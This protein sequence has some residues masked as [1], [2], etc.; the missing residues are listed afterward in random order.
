VAGEVR[1]LR[2][3]IEEAWA[4]KSRGALVP[5]LD[6]ARQVASSSATVDYLPLHAASLYLVGNL[7]HRIGDAAAAHATLLAAARAAAMAGDDW[8]VANTWVFLVLVLGVGLGRAAEAET[9]AAVAEVALARV[10]ENASLRSRLDNYRAASLATAGR[11]EEAAEALAHAVA[12]DE[13]THGPTHWFLVM[14][15]LNLAEVWLDAGQPARARP[16]LER[17]SAICR[18]DEGPPNASRARCLALVGRALFAYGNAPAATKVLE[19][20]AA[21]WEQMPGRESA[22]ADA[23]VDLAACRRAAGDLPGAQE[24]AGRAAWLLRIAPDR[25]AHARLAAERERLDGLSPP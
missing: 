18:P 6:L 14:S 16:P 1:R 7:E 15:L 25:R 3:L 13:R 19:R 20:A 11:H 9:M 12:L 2:G 5:A 21:L 4:K 10:G 22:L 17:A 24:L 23:L 8:Q